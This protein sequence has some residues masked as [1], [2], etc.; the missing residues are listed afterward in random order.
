MLFGALE[1][2]WREDANP[3][4]R[5]HV[6]PYIHRRP[7]LFRLHGVTSDVDYSHL[8]WTVDTE[9]DLAFA[10]RVYDHFGHDAFSWRDVLRLLEEHRDWA[11]I[12]SHVRQK[13]V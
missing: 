12:N 1:R 11:E 2:A 4:W 5:E 6:T 13:E 9:E 3:A 10:R 7:D 8:R